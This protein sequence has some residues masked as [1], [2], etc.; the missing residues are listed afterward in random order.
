MINIYEKGKLSRLL[1]CLIFSIAIT[2]NAQ[3][4]NLKEKEIHCSRG[5]YFIDK[6]NKSSG[7][8][9]IMY[10]K[11]ASEEFEQAFYLEPE[12]KSV[13]QWLLTCYLNLGEIDNAI[14]LYNKRLQNCKAAERHQIWEDI[15]QAYR[16]WGHNYKKAMESY[17]KAVKLTADKLAIARYYRNIGII[18]RDYLQDKTSYKKYRAMELQ[19]YNEL[20]K[21]KDYSYKSQ[22][23]KEKMFY[24]SLDNDYKNAVMIYEELVKKYPKTID[25]HTKE[26]AKF[27]YQQL[28]NVEKI[29]NT[30]C[31]IIYKV[32]NHVREK[33]FEEAVRIFEVFID[34]SPASFGLAQNMYYDIFQAYQE[35]HMYS[36][37][38]YLAKKKLIL[39]PPQFSSQHELKLLSPLYTSYLQDIKDINVCKIST[40]KAVPKKFLVILKKNDGLHLVRINSEFSDKNFHDQSTIEIG[41]YTKDN[42][43]IQ[44]KTNRMLVKFDVPELPKGIEIYKSKLFFYADAH[45][46]TQPAP[47]EV[48]LGAY[49]LSGEWDP[50]KVTWNKRTQ[51]NEWHNIGGDFLIKPVCINS[52]EDY[53]RPDL[54]GSMG[55][56]F[57]W[58]LTPIFKQ[59]TENNKA[60]LFGILLKQCY[61]DIVYRKVLNR[62]IAVNHSFNSASSN[63]VIIFTKGSA[64]AEDVSHFSEYLEDYHTL[65]IDGINALLQKNLSEVISY[66]VEAS[67]RADDEKIKS[68][69][70]E[71]I[72]IVTDF[73]REH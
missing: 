13:E 73:I 58:D 4:L 70:K 47:G 35:L 6:S 20:Y 26:T 10:Y 25:Q 11:K 57:S 24:Y 50:Q 1:Y 42:T 53:Y 40:P 68:T 49:K 17:K 54:A 27:L 2:V 38:L 22:V 61:E 21:Q 64:S 43:N 9:R 33:K 15:A 59:Y 69:I 31:G 65:Y 51:A 63:L 30:E 7:K 44:H 39:L 71:H 5:K 19:K 8:N 72:K 23:L 18:Y 36:K 41:I 12:D 37:A 16:D 46:G 45:T 28:G 34:K 29:K 60:P 3:N 52:W 48:P 32:E 55:L 67:K 56:V 66:W 14:R 62:K